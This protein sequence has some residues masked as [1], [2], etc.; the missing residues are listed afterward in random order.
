[1]VEEDPPGPP[2]TPGHGRPES[3]R[4]E[5]GWFCR[6]PQTYPPAGGALSRLTGGHFVKG[7]IP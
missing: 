3:F 7:M 5:P 4:I 2:A 6:R 1:M